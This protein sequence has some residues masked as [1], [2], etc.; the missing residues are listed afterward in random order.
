[1]ESPKQSWAPCHAPP[2]F[3]LTGAESLRVAAGFKDWAAL[4]REMRDS[5]PPTDLRRP[6]TDRGRSVRLDSGRVSIRSE[7][8]VAEVRGG[9]RRPPGQRSHGMTRYLISFDAHAMDHI[10]G[11]DMPAMMIR[12]SLEGR[13]HDLSRG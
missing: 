4:R 3:F 2:P 13:W 11:E 6:R 9:R 12:P 1:V 7:A 10:A 8:L 5:R